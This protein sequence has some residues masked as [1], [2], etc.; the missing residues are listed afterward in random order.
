MNIRSIDQNPEEVAKKVD[1]AKSRILSKEDK[2]KIIVVYS[3]LSIEI[4]KQVLLQFREIIREPNSLAVTYINTATPERA[5]A[6]MEFLRTQNAECSLLAERTP[7]TLVY[8][9]LGDDTAEEK[10]VAHYIPQYATKKSFFASTKGKLLFIEFKNWEDLMEAWSR[11]DSSLSA[12]A[13]LLRETEEAMSEKMSVAVLHYKKNSTENVKITASHIRAQLDIC[14]ITKYRL[15]PFE[16]RGCTVVYLQKTEDRERFL[17]EQAWFV[18]NDSYSVQTRAPRIPKGPPQTKETALITPINTT[19]TTDM[20]T[21]TTTTTRTNP[22]APNAQT[23]QD[24]QPA[25]QATHAQLAQPA[26][27]MQLVQPAQSNGRPTYASLL[28]I[29]A[30]GTANTPR[31]DNPNPQE[32]TPICPPALTVNMVERMILEST[33]VVSET[34]TTSIMNIRAEF[35]TLTTRVDTL[36]EIKDSIAN[37]NST[38]T[39]VVSKLDR[40]EAAEQRQKEK[41]TLGTPLINTF[42]AALNKMQAHLTEQIA[43][44]LTET[45]SEIARISK[46]VKRF[47]ETSP[48]QGVSYTEKDSKKLP[49]PQESDLDSQCGDDFTEFEDNL[50]HISSSQP[51][52]DEDAEKS[53]EEEKQAER[54]KQE[55]KPNASKP[56]TRSS[57]KKGGKNGTAGGVKPS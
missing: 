35:R 22:P 13:R 50:S 56:I 37:L 54:S 3:T 26:Q 24:M 1:K 4:R 28:G 23:T 46:R 42:Q 19:S 18:G 12:P 27:H 52:D 41:D 5:K 36:A 10:D 2:Q 7:V 53:R 21:T 11:T 43:T 9:F 39:A 33:K 20:L 44:N 25:Q 17:R 57:T 15:D 6:V 32:A 30:Q 14:G 16:N 31:I 38:V 45:R 48:V 47:V 55:G 29:S 40:L 51:D 49:D 34:L 8:T